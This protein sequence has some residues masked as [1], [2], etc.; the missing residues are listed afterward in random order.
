MKGTYFSFMFVHVHMCKNKLFSQ[1]ER[2]RF[3]EPR[4]TK[5]K[6]S[7]KYSSKFN[8]HKFFNW[9]RKPHCRVISELRGWKWPHLSQF[10]S[11]TSRSSL[12]RLHLIPC[13]LQHR[14]HLYWYRNL[15]VIFLCYRRNL[16]NY[17]SLWIV[18]FSISSS[19]LVDKV[20][21]GFRPQELYLKALGRRS[22]LRVNFLIKP[23][24]LTQN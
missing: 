13:T 8:S 24:P 20:L 9:P 5:K 12:K 19:A 15:I 10:R 2:R 4:K 16:I 23:M 7:K 17:S 18:W 21:E 6:N 3:W 1:L 14:I 22:W 11:N